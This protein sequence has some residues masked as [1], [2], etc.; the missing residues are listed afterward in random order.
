MAV[1]ILPLLVRLASRSTGRAT[2]AVSKGGKDLAQ[3]PMSPYWCVRASVCGFT[4][5]RLGLICI[6]CAAFGGRETNLILRA[7]V[8][9]SS[10]VYFVGV[11]AESLL[12]HGATFVSGL[13]N[14]F[15]CGASFPQP[16]RKSHVSPGVSC[17]VCFH[18]AFNY[19]WRAVVSL[20]T[21][22]FVHQSGKW[23][24]YSV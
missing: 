9:S 2:L 19:R 21:L 18:F 13:Q 1:T 20:C 14:S 5:S 16:V 4:L 12:T 17:L 6:N 23:I 10:D 24:P 15:G 7:V 11:N 3:W 8:L 22:W